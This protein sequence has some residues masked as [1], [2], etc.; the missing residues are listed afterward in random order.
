MGSD[1]TPRRL[2]FLGNDPAYFL[3]MRLPVAL[4]AL[5]AGYT[6]HVACP[7]ATTHAPLVRTGLVLHDIPMR[8]HGTHPADEWRTLKA[9]TALVDTL[10]PDVIHAVGVKAIL[11]GGLVARQRPSTRLVATF[12]GLGYAFSGI[13]RR[14]KAIRAALTPLLALGLRGRHAHTMV[15]NPDDGRILVR[16]GIVSERALTLVRGSGVDL[17]VWDASPLPASDPPTVV[18]ASRLLWDKG[19]G[20]LVQASRILRDRGIAARIV[21][22]GRVEPASHHTV[23]EA[24]LDAWSSDGL[25]AYAGFVRDVPGLLAS[26][27]LVV[28]PSYYREGIPRALIEAA[29]CGRPLVTTDHP[30]C[31]ETVDDGVNGRLVPPRDPDAL[32]DALAE[33]LTDADLRS[34]MGAASRAKAVAEFSIEHVVAQTLAVYDQVLST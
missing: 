17:S 1:A 11:H 21:I 3:R 12:A 6:V 29:A 13:D 33:L 10:R 15:Q 24:D 20:E 18:M 16:A 22:A 8:P 26:A 34:R 7:G 30:G 28:L 25:I 27:D 9:T 31:R 4:G 19:V 5:D 14:S 23:T 32:A 2:L